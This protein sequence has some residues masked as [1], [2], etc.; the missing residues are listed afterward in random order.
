MTN[1]SPT[2]LLPMHEHDM[3]RREDVQELGGLGEVRVRREAD[4]LHAHAQ[5][6]RAA[7]AGGDGTG[8]G[9]YLPAEGRGGGGGEVRVEVSRM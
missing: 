4:G 6:Q 3:G 7:L 5:M 1:D 9:Q 2:L 8:L